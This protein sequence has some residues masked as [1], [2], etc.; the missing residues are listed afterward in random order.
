MASK[1]EIKATTV[2][3]IIS[4]ILLLA[5]VI[6]GG[7]HLGALNP[8]YY[9]IQGDGDQISQVAAFTS[10]EALHAFE[11]A[12]DRLRR[13]SVDTGKY[14]FIRNEVVENL[15]DSLDSAHP[16][17]IALLPA[18]FK[19]LTLF[20]AD[21]P[22]APPQGAKWFWVRMYLGEAESTETMVFDGYHLWSR[23]PYLISLEHVL[24]KGRVFGSDWTRAVEYGETVSDQLK[25]VGIDF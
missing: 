4:A 14:T 7:R 9:K 6:I 24:N 18:G 10:P 22:V 21:G 23:Q 5:L 3:A 2:S 13:A 11:R 15:V 16:G 8:P 17:E 12:D 1:Y 25:A 19:Y 20:E